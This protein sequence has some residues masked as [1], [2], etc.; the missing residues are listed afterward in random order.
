[1][2]IP[3]SV[4]SID[5]YALSYCAN[6]KT[7]DIASSS[8]KT[9]KSYAFA[10]TTSLEAVDLPD[11]LTV[12]SSCKLIVTSAYSTRTLRERTRARAACKLTKIRAHLGCFQIVVPPL[13]QSSEQ[14]WDK[15]E[16]TIWNS[17]GSI[18]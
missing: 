17:Q 6:L 13:S 4:E 3:A 14:L 5:E 7:I 10:S 8:V 18:K 16:T 11:T 2:A 15:G 9:I 1:M 12:I